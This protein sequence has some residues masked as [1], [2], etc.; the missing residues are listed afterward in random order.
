MTRADLLN[1]LAQHGPLGYV[2][3]AMRRD[4]ATVEADEPLAA[5]AEK[6]QTGQVRSMMRAA[7]R[8]TGGLADAG[9]RAGI[10]A[11]C[12]RLWKRM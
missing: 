12:K 9:E 2:A 3:Q 1:A 8:S 10:R 5:A 7:R 11:D 4:F 6:L